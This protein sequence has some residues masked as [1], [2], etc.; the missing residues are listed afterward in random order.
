MA[1]VVALLA[2]VLQVVDRD[3]SYRA[4]LLAGD[5][6]LA[7]ANS[8]AAIAHYSAALGLRPDS[9]AAHIRRGQAYRE[10]RLTDDAIRDW[11]EAGKLA[12]RSTQPFELL[13]DLYSSLGQ[14]AQAASQYERCVA[15]DPL[16]ARRQYK[17]GLA[18]Y[19]AG[20]PQAAVDPLTRAVGLNDNFAEAYYLLGLVLRDTQA[21]PQAVDALERALR[22][23]PSL[24]PAR[25]ELADLY[26]A[27]GR[28]VEELKQLQSLATLDPQT[29]RTVAIA[30]AEAR[31]G[32]FDG[33][34]STLANAAALDPADA[35][36][37]LALGRVQ[38]LKSER[39]LDRR[40]VTAALAALEIA[41]QTSPRRSEAL[42]L[43]GRALYLSG[44][45][46]GA[47]H[48]LESAIAATPAVNEAYGYL[49]DAAERQNDLERARTALITL[50]TL[51]GDTATA[52]VRAARARR[53]GV[54]ALKTNLP[55]I[56]R[57][58]LQRAVDG[59]VKDAGTLALLAEAQWRDGREDDAR[60]TLSE[61]ATID[62][63]HPDVIRLRR[64]IR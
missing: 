64:L 5:Q 38:V 23:S 39:T 19:R 63:R 20:T 29:S 26:R 60:R 43:L 18:R 32:Q 44:D 31:Q 61:A 34:I 3:R 35:D 37:Q 11:Q 14:D 25:E 22:L 55:P 58:Q 24:T 57:Q 47:L 53:I 59:G 54:L 42:S 40:A 33:A 8:F 21:E 4:A 36:V 17:L 6:A 45:T 10:Q 1:T 30:L 46:T 16:D 51:E 2:I 9:V 13:G 62:A 15:L 41:L 28:P 56:A 52:A 7:G 12:P 48:T 50:D 49:A 27:M